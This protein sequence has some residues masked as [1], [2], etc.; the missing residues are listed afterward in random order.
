MQTAQDA[1]SGVNPAAELFGRAVKVA[2]DMLAGQRRATDSAGV[3]MEADHRIELRLRRRRL[4]NRSRDLCGIAGKIG[5][6]P[7]IAL[8]RR[9]HRA[10]GDAGT[11]G[12]PAD[13]P[14]RTARA[15][16]GIGFEQAVGPLARATFE[17]LDE[18]DTVVTD[19]VW[20]RPVRLSTPMLA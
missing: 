13:R 10:R 7:R 12:P 5:F 3:V 18:R 15:G 9:P 2:R 6:E 11:S 14:G 20:C 16:V 1:P 17:L 8:L 4:A 19:G